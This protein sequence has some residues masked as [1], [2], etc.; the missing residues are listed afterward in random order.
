MN[1]NATLFPE[2]ADA[3]PLVSSCKYEVTV[4]PSCFARVVIAFEG[5]KSNQVAVTL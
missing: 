4:V 1:T 2:A 3:A 5:Y